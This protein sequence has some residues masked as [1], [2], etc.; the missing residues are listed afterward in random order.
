MSARNLRLEGP[1]LTPTEVSELLGVPIGTLKMWRYR[2]TGPR[3]LK[4]GRH[5]RYRSADISDWLDRVAV[6]AFGDT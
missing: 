1:L 3:W 4:L 5:I 2:R 6:T